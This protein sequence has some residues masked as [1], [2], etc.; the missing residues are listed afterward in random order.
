[1]IE[2][3]AKLT[4]FSSRKERLFSNWE[5]NRQSAVKGRLHELIQAE[6][7]FDSHGQKERPYFVAPLVT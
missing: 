3:D 1:M 4:A 7:I 2:G 5:P 6:S